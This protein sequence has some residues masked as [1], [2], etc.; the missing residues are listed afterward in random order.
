MG[1]EGWA[2][3]CTLGVGQAGT[4]SNW[5]LGRR[6][7]AIVSPPLSGGGGETPSLG[8]G[9]KT[10]AAVSLGLGGAEGWSPASGRTSRADQTTEEAV[11]VATLVPALAES[12]TPHRLSCRPPLCPPWPWGARGGPRRPRCQSCSR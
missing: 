3:Y 8:L 11:R 2:P 9:K 10:G 6:L 4:P 7:E 12:I 5:S 1:R